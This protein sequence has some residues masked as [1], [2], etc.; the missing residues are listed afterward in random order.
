MESIAQREARIEG[1]EKD[2]DQDHAFVKELLALHDKFMT[3]VSQQFEGH[4]LLQRALKDAF[5]TI[6]NKVGVQY[7]SCYCV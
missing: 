5:V 1:G 7:V 2:T 6:A 3:T 4:S